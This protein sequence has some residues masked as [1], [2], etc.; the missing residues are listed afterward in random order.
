MSSG[1]THLRWSPGLL[2]L[3]PLLAAGSLVR[4]DEF[5]DLR[6]KWRDILT[7]GTNLDLGDPVVQSR[8]ASIAGRTNLWADA[9]GPTQS[10]F[11]VARA[12]RA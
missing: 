7:G 5:D 3:A 12:L 9:A 11:V 4:A 8:I 1:V 10:G 2:F 6:I